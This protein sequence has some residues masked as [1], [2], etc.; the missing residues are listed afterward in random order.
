[1]RM[2]MLCLDQRRAGGVRQDAPALRRAIIRMRVDSDDLW[3]MVVKHAIE[4]E[5]LRDFRIGRSVF[6]IAH[7]LAEN[8]FAVLNEAKG[9]LELRAHSQRLQIFVE[10]RRK[11]DRHWRIAARAP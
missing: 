3:R 4:I 10:T 7:V 11:R 2:V 9:V 5:I 1:M 6:E 8:G